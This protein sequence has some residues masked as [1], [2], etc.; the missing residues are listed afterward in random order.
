MF[1]LAA[2]KSMAAPAKL[3]P[4]SWW[5]GSETLVPNGEAPDFPALLGPAAW[6]RLAPAI[7]RRF[8]PWHADAPVTYAGRMRIERSLAGLVFALAAKLIG[9]PLPLGA[10]PDAE[11]EVRVE[12]DGRGGVVWTR[13]LRML[14]GG[15]VLVVRSTKRRDAQ[16][17]LLE[18]VDGGLGMVLDV[19]EEEQ[20]LVFESRSYFLRLLGVRLPIPAIATPGVCRVVHADRGGDQF[21][22]TLSFVHPVWGR[23]FVQDGVFIDPHPGE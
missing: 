6:L 13:R 3:L 20:A 19:F 23:T 10:A 4:S 5:E 12:S 2:R 17:R 18:C 9:G 21:R 15:P 11:A 16:G 22:F 14:G 8:A 7:R 1:S